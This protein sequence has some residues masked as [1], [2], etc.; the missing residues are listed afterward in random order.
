MTTRTYKRVNRAD[1]RRRADA[2]VTARLTED[3]RKQQDWQRRSAGTVGLH[4]VP[5]PIATPG[6][7]GA[8]RQ[9]VDASVGAVALCGPNLGTTVWKHPRSYLGLHINPSRRVEES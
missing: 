5:M 7:L 4:T 8:G 3:L 2:I 9:V 6:L 1:V